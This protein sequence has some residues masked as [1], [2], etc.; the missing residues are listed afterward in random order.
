MKTLD[1]TGQK[2]GRLVVVKRVEDHVTSGGQK[3]AMYLCKCRCG[4]T[5]VIQSASLKSKKTKSCGC[6][7]LEKI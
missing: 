7:N 4:N 6:I 5:K 1:L 2:F 3:K